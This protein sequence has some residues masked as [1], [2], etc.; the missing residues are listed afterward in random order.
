M[1][2]KPTD[3]LEFPAEMW[4]QFRLTAAIK[5]TNFSFKPLYFLTLNC[6]LLS[7]CLILFFNMYT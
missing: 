4:P 1:T 6:A 3:E 7:F 5:M 2:I